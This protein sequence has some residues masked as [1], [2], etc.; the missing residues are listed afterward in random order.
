MILI[1]YSGHAYV[2]CSILKSAGIS[3]TGYCDNEEKAQNPFGLIYHGKEDAAPGLAALTNNPFF[4]AIG[5][6]EVRKKIYESL[7]AKNLLPG[8]V[9]HASAIICTTASIATNGVMISGGVVINALS[10]VGRGTIC[11]TGCIIEH[12]CGIG[13]FV[14]IGPGAILCG[15]VKVGHLSFIGAGAIIRQGIRIG[16]N[17]MIGAGAVVVKDVPDNTRLMGNPAR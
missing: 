16:E 12:E 9:T 13:D 7:A 3:P 17:V 5:N 1:G 4:I 8:S 6:N 2:V 15:N 10:S 14:H 11:N